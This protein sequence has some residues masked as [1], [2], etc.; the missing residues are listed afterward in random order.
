MDSITAGIILSAS[1][2]YQSILQSLVSHAP[3]QVEVEH[4][5]AMNGF[6]VIRKEDQDALQSL[7]KGNLGRI[8]LSLP[9]CLDMIIYNRKT[10]QYTVEKE[11][12]LTKRSVLGLL[13]YC[14]S[15]SFLKQNQLLDEKPSD[16]LNKRP[17][18]F[19]MKT[20]SK[21]LKS[22]QLEY[23]V[24]NGNWTT[25]G[26]SNASKRL[27]FATITSHLYWDEEIIM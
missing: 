18:Q 15:G 2:R 12:V 22:M 13:L 16:M 8:S 26:M 1:L 20:F 14:C 3:Q 23:A 25:R 27:R 19:F 24:P 17:K 4:L 6:A 7:L 9:T 11:E 21:F 5:E 10:K